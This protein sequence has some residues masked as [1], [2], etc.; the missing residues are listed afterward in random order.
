VKYRWS[1]ALITT[2]NPEP[3]PKPVVLRSL[4]SG[5]FLDNGCWDVS[6]TV[7]PRVQVVLTKQKRRTM[8]ANERNVYVS[9]TILIPIGI[10]T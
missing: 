3:S 10:R 1:N 5:L 6:S 2:F 9:L 4:H 7:G 8:S